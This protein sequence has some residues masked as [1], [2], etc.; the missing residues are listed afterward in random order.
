MGAACLRRWNNEQSPLFAAASLITALQLEE[1]KPSA[2]PG[3][4]AQFIPSFAS[5]QQGGAFC[6]ET[7][8]P[9]AQRWYCRRRFGQ[10]YYL[11]LNLATHVFN[12][13][14]VM[15]QTC[16]WGVYLQ[17][18]IRVVPANEG[19]CLAACNHSNELIFQGRIV[20]ILPG[21]K[22]K[23]RRCLFI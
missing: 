18:Y 17:S 12:N 23:K 22:Q 11:P 16:A 9:A 19:N 13:G 15:A 4:A 1:E 3:R 6:W 7:L 10:F 2:A 8:P 14:G 21:G 20:I 5:F